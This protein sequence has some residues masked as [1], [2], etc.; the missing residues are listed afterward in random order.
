MVERGEGGAIVNMSSVA[1]LRAVNN[2]TIYCS[3]KGAMD[4]LTRTMALELGPHKVR[5]KFILTFILA[6]SV[7]KV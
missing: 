5:L 3:A 4:M 1:G 2:H 6:F 7:K